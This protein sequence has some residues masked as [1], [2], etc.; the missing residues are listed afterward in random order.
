MKK[1]DIHTTA[2]GNRK[3]H[4]YGKNGEHAHEYYWNKDG[5]FDYRVTRELTPKEQKGNRKIL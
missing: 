1:L 2:H 3:Q 4:P 5:G